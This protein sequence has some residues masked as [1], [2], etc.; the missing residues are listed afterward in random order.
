[1]DDRSVSA[2]AAL[3]ERFRLRPAALAPLTTLAEVLIADPLAP[4]TVREPRRVLD[5][6]LADSLVALEL[7]GG[8]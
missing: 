5:D 6:H 3:V 2:I 7:P 1:M 4:T 8:M